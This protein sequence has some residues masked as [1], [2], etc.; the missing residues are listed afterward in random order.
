M[1]L[2][3]FFSLVSLYNIRWYNINISHLVNLNCTFEHNLCAWINLKRDDQR[4]WKL[5]RGKTPTGRTGPSVDHTTNSAQ[6]NIYESQVGYKC[7]S[8]DNHGRGFVT[9]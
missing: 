8:V 6:G 1:N 3:V 9:G 5:N 7:T 4:D 2:Y